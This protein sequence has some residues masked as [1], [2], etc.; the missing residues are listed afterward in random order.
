MKNLKLL[1][2]ITFIIVSCTQPV[3]KQIRKPS[4]PTHN[5]AIGASVRN[6][7]IP[8]NYF[9]ANDTV[10]I[11]SLEFGKALDSP[12]NYLIEDNLY[13]KFANKN[14]STVERDPEMLKRLYAETG[15]RYTWVIDTLWNLN[16]LAESPIQRATKIVAYRVLDCGIKS[17]KPIAVEA[18]K[19]GGC[20]IFAGKAGG[21]CIFGGGAIM[22]RMLQRR[23]ETHLGV[24][25][26]N[27]KTGDILW[28]DY[29]SGVAI[30]TIPPDL[31]LAL[32]EKRLT[33]YP[34]TLPNRALVEQ[35]MVPTPVPG[36]TPAPA[37]P[38]YP[39]YPYPVPPPE[40]ITPRITPGVGV[41]KFEAA[42]FRGANNLQWEPW[43]GFCYTKTGGSFI[44]LAP[45]LYLN[46]EDKQLLNISFNLWFDSE[47]LLA[48]VMPV[49]LF[50]YTGIGIGYTVFHASWRGWD[51]YELEMP[52]SWGLKYYLTDNLSLTAG[53][54]FHIMLTD[55]LMSYSALTFGIGIH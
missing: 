13:E 42:K 39:C 53:M 10:A 21:C 19:A 37:A 34:H 55:D 11:W 24:R 43:L 54:R 52:I 3:L 26:I 16:M 40:V 51:A 36:I 29:I 44:S 46:F 31:L 22:Q 41:Q 14:I 25:I 6:V 2:L 35:A 4:Y 12:V 5:E 28:S 27:A 9:S 50:E 47:G 32:G 18:G 7:N 33:Q 38:Y 30:D 45:S 49:K 15:Y 1:V 8:M 20:C 48:K 17:I 23:A